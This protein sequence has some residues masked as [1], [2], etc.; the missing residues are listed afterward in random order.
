MRLV[1]LVVFF[2]GWSLYRTFKNGTDDWE[3]DLNCGIDVNELPDIIYYP[4]A[5][6]WTF[7]KRSLVPLIISSLLYILCF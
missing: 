7:L 1:A 2:V 4:I 3:V 6:F 5:F